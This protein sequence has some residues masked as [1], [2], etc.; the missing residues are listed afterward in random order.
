M[1]DIRIQ[2]KQYTEELRNNILYKIPYLTQEIH[3]IKDCGSYLIIKG[4]FHSKSRIVELI[5]E[6]AERM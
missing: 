6:L 2:F 5:N 4:D 3:E 1:E